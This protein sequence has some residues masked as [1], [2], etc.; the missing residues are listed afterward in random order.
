MFLIRHKNMWCGLLC[1]FYLFCLSSANIFEGEWDIEIT[2]SPTVVEGTEP[3]QSEEFDIDEDTPAPTPHYFLNLTRPSAHS[4]V[5]TGVLSGHRLILEFT[6]EFSGQVR[7]THRAQQ[8]EDEFD[9]ELEEVSDTTSDPIDGTEEILF[10]FTLV[11]RTN[12]FLVSQGPGKVPNQEAG[13]YQLVFADPYSFILTIT[14]KGDWLAISGRKRVTQEEKGFFQRMSL[15]MMMM[16]FF[17]V[18]KIFQP[19]PQL[20]TPPTARTRQAGTT[21]QAPSPENTVD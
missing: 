16:A 15:P 7:C 10:Q 19:K 8:N 5:L 9:T 21:P 18:S 1:F 12:N 17:L 3:Q 2:S 13:H 4:P 14:T 6:S 20:P 11:N